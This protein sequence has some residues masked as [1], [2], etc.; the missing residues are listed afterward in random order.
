MDVDPPKAPGD[1]SWLD[2][3]KA[4]DEKVAK[5]KAAVAAKSAPASA[6]K[7]EPKPE[8]KAAPKTTGISAPTR[9]VV[10]SARVRL[11]GF[12]NREAA[13][14]TARGMLEKYLYNERPFAA[15]IQIISNFLPTLVK[16][17]PELEQQRTSL[18]L[19]VGLEIAGDRFLINELEGMD[20]TNMTKTQVSAHAALLETLKRCTGLETRFPWHDQWCRL[21]GLTS[22]AALQKWKAN[23]KLVAEPLRRHPDSLYPEPFT[24]LV[25]RDN[26]IPVFDGRPN[27]YKEY[28]MRIMLYFRKMSLQNRKGE[29][30]INLLTSLSGTAWEHMVDSA[31]EQEDG[32]EKVI[33]QLDLAFKYDDRVEMPRT[34]ERFFYNL[35]RKPHQNLL[36]YC[37]EHRE[38]LREV[39]RHKVVIPA[40]VS[41]W[42][43]LC[44]AGLTAEQRQLVLGQ[45][46]SDTTLEKME[47]ALYYLYGQD[48]IEVEVV[49]LEVE[50]LIE[51]PVSGGGLAVVVVPA[52]I[53][54]ATLRSPSLRVVLLLVLPGEDA[55]WEEYE[56]HEFE[57]PYDDTEEE[58]FA[59]YLD[60]RKKLAE[61]RSAR[62]YYPVVALTDTNALADLPPNEHETL[63]HQAPSASDVANQEES[64][65]LEQ[66]VDQPFITGMQDGGA[67]S[68]LCGHDVLMNLIA[69]FHQ[70]GLSPEE[71]QFSRTNKS[72]RFGG[73]NSSIS[74]WSVHLPVFMAATRAASR[75]SLWREGHDQ[76]TCSVLNE[77]WQPATKGPMGEYLLRLDDGIKDALHH[78][79]AFDYM[80][81]DMVTDT[82]RHFLEFH[83]LND[84]LSDTGRLGPELPEVAH[85]AE[86]TTDDNLMIDH[87]TDCNMHEGVTEPVLCHIPQKMWRTFDVALA[88]WSN[89]MN[90][91]LNSISKHKPN[92]KKVFWEVYSGIS[93]L[94][95]AMEAECTRAFLQFQDE[96][97]PD[98]V[99][100]APPCKKWSRMQNINQRTAEQTELLQL[101]RAYEHTT[102]LKFTRRVY[103]RQ[104]RGG[105]Q[106]YVEQRLWSLAWKTPALQL[107]GYRAIF[108]QCAYGAGF[109]TSP[110]AWH[111]IRKPTAVLSTEESF[112]ETMSLKCPG[113][114]SHVALQGSRPGIGSLTT[115]AAAYQ[116]DMC[117]A[118]SQ[119]ICTTTEQR[120]MSLRHDHDLERTG[121]LQKIRY[122]NPVESQRLVARLHRGASEAVILAAKDY[123]CELCTRYARPSQT[124]KAA[125]RT[126]SVFNQRLQADTLWIQIQ[127]KP[128]PV[129]TM[130]DAATRYMSARVLPTETSQE[131]LNAVQRGWIRTFG[132]PQQLQVDSHRGWCSDLVRQFTGEHSIELIISP[133][134]AHERLSLLERRHQVLRRAIDI[135]IAE[136]GRD[137]IQGLKD[138]L[139]FT[140]QALNRM[141]TYKGFSPNQWVLGYQPHLPGQLVEENLNPTQLQPSEQFQQKLQL[142]LQASQAILSANADARLRRALLRQYRGNSEPLSIGNKVFYWRDAAGTGPKVKWKGAAVVMV[143]TDGNTGKPRCYWLVHGSN[144]LRAA[145]EH[146]RRTLEDMANTESDPHKILLD[147]RNR[148]TTTYVDLTKSNKRKID[149]VVSDEE[150]DDPDPK[151][152]ASSP[153]TTAL[154]DYWDIAPDGMFFDRVHV[155]PR[156]QLF[157][158][159]PEDPDIPYQQ[160]GSLRHTEIYRLMPDSGKCTTEAEHRNDDWHQPFDSHLE[161]P[162]TWTG[163]TRFVKAENDGDVTMGV[164]HQPSQNRLYHPMHNQHGLIYH[165]PRETFEEQRRRVDRQETISYGPNTAR[166]PRPGPY[167]QP[168]ADENAEYAF[169]VDILNGPDDLTN[170][171]LPLPPG[172]SVDSSGHLVLEPVHDTWSISKNGNYLIG[173]HYVA[174]NSLFDPRE[175]SNCPI[176]VH[177]LNKIRSTRFADGQA[178]QDRWRSSHNDFDNQSYWT[179]RT[180]FKILPRDREQAHETFYHTSEGHQT[181]AGSPQQRKKD[182]KNLSIKTL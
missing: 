83:N 163:R 112:A 48:F 42:L 129:L 24:L 81:N 118:L 120:L 28:R 106:A 4:A 166:V 40:A 99:W 105:R 69:K 73:D 67:S 56:D 168:P 90:Y 32:F 122:N 155:A 85:H 16:T 113:N 146:V 17:S 119:A 22:R 12:S 176:P 136:T 31:P 97:L 2:M 138:A 171:S 101:D 38:H 95:Q 134:E 71:F 94:S 159:S 98:V 43:L 174:R 70:Q 21:A 75:P 5:A 33:S 1:K 50:L 89:H 130:L 76:Q 55:Y 91:H 51:A 173:N 115:A 72:F 58:V 47:G 149:D 143:E 167:N 25:T 74:T 3:A 158:P 169:K 141:S 127:N 123:Q 147:L 103:L 15:S 117:E 170:Q 19:P 41:S 107:G 79:L 82:D 154:N 49:L 178:R 57:Q 34:F 87:H 18:R 14:E 139:D 132:P 157:C 165:N 131:F 137:S 108:D 151:R 59:T 13:A 164:N 39:E 148:G 145:P 114:H 20:T 180:T 26:Y 140:V 66:P 60:A 10:V 161:L 53:A 150:T 84:Y 102:N 62:G 125:T 35:S 63:F 29:A 61:H 80:T 153:T 135:V 86:C 44:R 68:V 162:Y 46:G 109:W 142:Q 77:P 52:V 179:G 175:D 6:G 93:N 172:W 100:L 156:Q 124:P 121:I 152:P 111:Y 182:S 144:L 104:Q 88:T 23:F 110:T 65:Y 36:A 128:V 96:E 9:R 133:G 160:F 11:I 78:D 7:D 27:N 126:T 181:Y 92:G 64:A 45:V 116:I 177:M 8:P 37:T 54:T 30:T